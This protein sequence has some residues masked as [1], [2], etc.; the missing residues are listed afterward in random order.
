[1]L[2][3]RV[4]FRDIHR[5]SVGPDR[6]KLVLAE[7]NGDASAIGAVLAPLKERLFE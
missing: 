1:M 5:Y 6:P 4:R 7:A 3:E 2:I